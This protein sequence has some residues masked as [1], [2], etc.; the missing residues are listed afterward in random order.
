MIVEI[1][2]RVR[3]LSFLVIVPRARKGGEMGTNTITNDEH[4]T[5]TS[6]EHGFWR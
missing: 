6:E 5:G 3:A 2:I 4:D 1:V